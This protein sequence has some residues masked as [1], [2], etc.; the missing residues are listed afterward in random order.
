M[1]RFPIKFGSGIRRFEFAI[2]MKFW[3]YSPVHVLKQGND[4]EG[5]EGRRRGRHP[6]WQPRLRRDRQGQGQQ[7]VRTMLGGALLQRKVPEGALAPE[8]RNH[9]AHCKPPP[10][11]DGA[12][13]SG[14]ALVSPRPPAATAGGE[15]DADWPEHPCPICFDN[16]DDHGQCGQC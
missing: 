12:P 4:G 13:A 16:E 5:E 11:P 6:L 8:R 14:P 9:K 1:L 10:K 7:E 3:I 2:E 15:D